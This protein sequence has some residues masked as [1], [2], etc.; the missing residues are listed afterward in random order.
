[1]SGSSLLDAIAALTKFVFL[2]PVDMTRRRRHA[3]KVTEGTALLDY[4]RAGLARW[5][6]STRNPWIASF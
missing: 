1:M 6:A 2:P 4:L 3:L 5:S